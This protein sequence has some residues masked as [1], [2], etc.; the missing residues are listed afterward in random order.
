MFHAVGVNSKK[1]SLKSG[2]LIGVE[3]VR[4]GTRPNLTET[5]DMFGL[6]HSKLGIYH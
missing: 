5:F 2:V 3:G 1:N 4:I 6:N